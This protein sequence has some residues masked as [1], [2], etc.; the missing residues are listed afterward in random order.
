MN[1]KYAIY[2]YACDMKSCPCVHIFCTCS[3]RTPP[4]ARETAYLTDSLDRHKQTG[5]RLAPK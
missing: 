2:Q 4:S 1:I 5:E 3:C